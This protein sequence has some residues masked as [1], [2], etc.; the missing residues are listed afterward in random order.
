MERQSAANESSEN[1]R[2]LRRWR[3]STFWVML[4][5]Y[6][7]YYLCRDNLPAAF[8]LLSEK[9]GFTNSQLGLIAFYSE[10]AYSAGKF[11]NGPLAD[12]LGG[13]KFFLLGM[14][15][16]IAFNV[17][18][19]FGST[20]GYFILIWCFAR[21]FLSMGW[22]GLIKVIGSW[23]E[24]ERHGTIMGIISINFQFGSVV[25]RYFSSA[26]VQLGVGWQGLFYYPAAIL[27]AIFVWSWFGSKDNP[28]QV[29]PG[30]KFGSSSVEKK[31][32]IEHGG[33]GGTDAIKYLLRLPMFQKLLLFSFISHI[34]RS[35]FLFWTPKLL[36]DIGMGNSDAIFKS[37]IFPFLGVIGTVLLGWYTD[38]FVKNG[39]RA[40]PMVFM[41]LGLGVCQLALA[42][43]TQVADKPYGLIVFLIGLSGFLLFGPYSMSSGVLSLD[44]AGHERAGSCTGLIDGVGYIGGALAVWGAGKMSD[45]GGWS[46]VFS[47]LAGFS[48]VAAFAALLLSRDLRRHFASVKRGT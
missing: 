11:I 7:G 36:L 27:S 24:H 38:R 41:L 8:G 2:R 14:F 42:H 40:R 19:T 25:A 1:L 3:V 17:L 15:G 39:D 10:L 29:I 33:S 31:S 35:V 4:I 9:F 47:S 26:L 46:H 48:L 16:S 37:A 45:A 20:I 18:F 6:I 21:Y 28:Q 22:G 43:F 30:T 34:L 5:G 23:Y 44:I 12:K 13:K 32:V